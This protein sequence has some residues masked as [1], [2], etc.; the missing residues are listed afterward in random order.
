MTTSASLAKLLRVEEGIYDRVGLDLHGAAE[1]LFRHDEVIARVVVDRSRIGTTADGRQLL[2]DLL[3]TREFPGALEEHVL[4]EVGHAGHLVRLVEI[5]GL[6]EGIDGHHSGAPGLAGEQGQAI[7][8]SR[9]LD[10][11]QK[12][13]ESRSRI[14]RFAPNGR[15]QRQSDSYR[16]RACLGFHG[17]PPQSGF[18]S[19]NASQTGSLENVP[20]RSILRAS[21]LLTALHGRP[22]PDPVAS[23]PRSSVRRNDEEQSWAEDAMARGG[24]QTRTAILVTYSGF[25]DVSRVHRSEPIPSYWRG[26]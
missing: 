1:A 14:V 26:T 5:P 6:D 17:K 11:L 2:R 7:G 22:T 13:I 18:L 23:G 25:P 19:S 4:E 9:L 16:Q 21:T 8:Q 3:S 10:A 15:S 24:V 12:R 20:A